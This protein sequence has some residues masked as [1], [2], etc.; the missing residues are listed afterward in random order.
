M[1]GDGIKFWSCWGVAQG[2]GSLP[3]GDQARKGVVSGPC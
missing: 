2:A 3:G 1:G